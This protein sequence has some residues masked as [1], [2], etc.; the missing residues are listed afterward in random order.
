[1]N[2]LLKSN[3]AASPSVHTTRTRLIPLIVLISAAGVTLPGCSRDEATVKDR[4]AHVVRVVQIDT[5]RP[6]SSGNVNYTGVVRARTESQL[7]FRVAGKISERLVNAGEAVKTGQPLLKLDATDYQ[8]ALQAARAVHKQA[9]LELERVRVLVEKR[10]ESRDVLEK[11]VA[12]AE[13]SAALAEQLANQAGYTTLYADAD[14]V[15][16]TTLAEPGQVVAAGQPVLV[17]AKDGPREAAVDIPERSLER[18]RG[19]QAT[20]QLYLNSEVRVPA[21]FREISGV[22]DPVARTYQARYVLEGD[23]AQFPLGATVTVRVTAAGDDAEKITE[24][25]LG[26][27]IDRGD[28][29]AVWV[30]DATTS[31][32]QKR[33]VSIAKLGAETASIRDGLKHGDVVVALGA[34]LLNPGETVRVAKSSPKEAK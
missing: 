4:A 21:T 13:S 6:A 7:G 24:I 9:S 14:G 34:Q 12:A 23:A 26:S 11:A 18:I 27:L 20:A 33:A 31:T 30:V 15:V 22:A 28:G 3:A 29:A 2:S 32:L 5:E 16:M 8:L 19:Q 1:M 17:L 10:A 25:P